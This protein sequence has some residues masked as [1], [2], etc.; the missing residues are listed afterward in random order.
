MDRRVTLIAVLVLLAAT[1]GCGHHRK[2]HAAI[3]AYDDAVPTPASASAG[4]GAAIFAQQCAACHGAQGAGGRIG[5]SLTGERE[6]KDLASVVAII[7]DPEPPM[8]KLFP[9]ELSA[10]DV[11]DLAAYIERL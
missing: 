4:R 11:E 3:A 10:Q 9:G 5:P 6:R 2:A 7:K 1:S 8:P